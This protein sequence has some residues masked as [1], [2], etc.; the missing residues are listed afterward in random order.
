MTR[1][2]KLARDI[3]TDAGLQA[4]S[5]AIKSFERRTSG[6]IVIS[7]NTRDHGQPYKQAKRIFQRQGLQKTKLRNG[8]LIVLF[9]E[10]H[11]FTIYGDEGIHSRLPENYWQET[12]ETLASKFKESSLADGLVWAVHE[13]GERL[14]EFFPL[15]ADDENE[16]K[17]DLQFESD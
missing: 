8:I 11:S 7:F 16:L 1:A 14:Q 2:E 15:A 13:L 12:V 5:A 10:D 6:E 4:I 3:I 17:D 9:L